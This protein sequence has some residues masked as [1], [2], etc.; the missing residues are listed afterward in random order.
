MRYDNFTTFP[1]D[2]HEWWQINVP[3]CQYHSFKNLAGNQTYVTM[4]AYAMG[5]SK[6]V[7]THYM[8][9]NNS[10]HQWRGHFHSL[11]VGITSD[12]ISI[13]IEH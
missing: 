2:I 9:A 4:S 5:K 11:S 13:L 7:S 8:T 1:P 6:V 3:N 12:Y 10:S